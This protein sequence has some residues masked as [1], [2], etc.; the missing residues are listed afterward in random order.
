MKRPPRVK[1]LIHNGI[2]IPEYRPEGFSINHRG[3]ETKLNPEQEEMAVNWVKKLETEYVKDPVFV[4]NFFRDFSKALGLEDAAPGDFDFSEIKRWVNQQKAIREQMSR[5]ER[6]R[7]AEERKRIREKNKEKYGYAIIDGEKVEIGNYMAE[8]A[9][10]FM[11]RGKHPLR[12][13]WKAGIRYSDVILNLSPDA[14]TPK[15]PTGEIWGGRTFEP[16]ALWVAKWKDR[17]SEKT[18]YIW[19]ADSARLKQVREKE[20]FDNARILEVNIE[21]VREHIL[22]NLDSEDPVRRQVSTAAYLIDVL[23]LRVG[24]EKESDEA[25]TVGATTLRGSH[26]KINSDNTVK[27]DFV[28]KDF[29]RW[30]KTIELPPQVVKNLKEFI[31]K[32]NEQIFT[33]VRSDLVNEF[34]NEAMPGL[35]AKV[36]RT[37]HATKI[38]SD[39]LG[40][41]RPSPDA[42]DSEKKYVAT[43]A[44][45]QAAVACHHKRKLPTKW[46]ES[47][48]RKG[49]SLHSLNLKLLE[50]REK[51][52]LSAAQET[53]KFHRR[54]LKRNGRLNS[55]RNRLEKLMRKR[56]TTS[57]RRQ[58][59]SLRKL[60]AA[61]RKALKAM[62]NDFK[63]KRK[64]REGAFTK[65]AERLQGR[66]EAAEGKLD[67]AKA[68]KNYNL[69][70]SLKSYIDPRTYA[71]WAKEVGYDW[72]QIYPKSLQRKFSW[73]EKKQN[74]NH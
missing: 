59:T 27:F 16:T 51:H 64:R 5:E 40:E 31:G 11:G 7:L 34:L 24:D 65:M 42:A 66:I 43:M 17:F 72:R 46:K 1:Q 38:V 50:L 3:Q 10:I 28:G 35:T 62:K 23:K 55:M 68:T 26:V 57:R 47:L 32:S 15:T 52:R 61:E 37:Y 69:G 18:K 70:T 60:I 39:Y 2:L 21:R 56:P 48:A 14:P 33:G 45:L 49:E 13:R 20:K 41:N 8:P 12:G 30:V 58:A 63:E 74:T 6:K 4:R 73:V 53:E 25:D 54:V 22:N 67:L 19:I 71:H 36:F 29:V 44:N 9:S